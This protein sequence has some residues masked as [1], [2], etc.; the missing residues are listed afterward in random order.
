MFSRKPFEWVP[1]F[2]GRSFIS[3]TSI[4]P[5]FESFSLQLFLRKTL[6]GQSSR[7]LSL[8]ISEASVLRFSVTDSGGGITVVTRGVPKGKLTFVLKASGDLRIR[9]RKMQW[10][11]LD[12]WGC[13]LHSD[14]KLAVG[15]QIGDIIKK[16][17]FVMLSG[18]WPWRMLGEGLGWIC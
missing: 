14:P 4:T 17:T 10:L 15:S 11:I 1:C 12:Y 7:S 8:I 9:I 3:P 6:N 13:L 18:S 16:Q 2:P 5:T